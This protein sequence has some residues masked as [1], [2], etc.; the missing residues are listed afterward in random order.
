MLVS[1]S[2]IDSAGKT[3][4]I[5][6]LLAYCKE[7]HIRAKRLWGKA[8][9]TPGVVFL[10]S[11][12]RRD[13]KMSQAEKL[14]YRADF[15]QSTKKKRFLLV[16][17]LLDLLWYFGIYYRIENLFHKITILDRYMWDTFIEVKTEFTGIEFENW[18]LW[19]LVVAVSPN[20]KHSFLF[21][22]PAEESLRR[23]IQKGDLTVDNMELK[24]EKIALYMQLK[25]EGKWKYIMD[26]MKSREELHESVRALL[27]I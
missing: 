5:E 7:N 26:G 2:G 10:K 11:L 6:M 3:T 8:R 4:Q 18:L 21:V 23:D 1:F 12:V 16:A 20:P 15:F 24:K 27:K 22:I 19:K 13:R 9:G 25:D 14:E 17:S